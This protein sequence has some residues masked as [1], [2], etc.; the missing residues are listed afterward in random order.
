M[1]VPHT[2][3]LVL[4]YGFELLLMAHHI[5]RTYDENRAKKELIETLNKFDK[6]LCDLEITVKK[7]GN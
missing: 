4:F 5:V 6:R 1:E 2:L 7:L 3:V